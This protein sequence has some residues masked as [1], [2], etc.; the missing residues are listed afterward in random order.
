MTKPLRTQFVVVDGARARWVRRSDET[1]DFVTENEIKAPP[2]APTGGPQGVVF[3][4][5]GGGR[6]AI[7]QGHG[8]GQKKD[9]FVVRVAEALNHQAEHGDFDRLAIVAPARTLNALRE[10]LSPAARERLAGAL[11]KDLTKVADHDLAK[12]LRPLELG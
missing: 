6:H 3:E 1:H 8:K 7:E 4:R 5:A 9:S 10:E 2:K 12:W 11:A